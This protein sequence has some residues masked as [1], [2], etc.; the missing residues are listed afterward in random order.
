MKPFPLNLKHFKKI[1]VDQHSSVLKHKDGHEIRIAH[2]SLKPELRKQ[3]DELPHYADGTPKGP[4]GSADDDQVVR[5]DPSNLPGSPGYNLSALAQTPTMNPE[6]ETPVQPAQPSQP[7]SP[8]SAPKSFAQSYSDLAQKQIAALEK[9]KKGEMMQAQALSSGALES[10]NRMASENMAYEQTMEPYNQNR[11]YLLNEHKNLQDAITSGQLDTNR[12]VN[13]MS[14]G[15][16]ILNSLGLIF[17]GFGAGLTHGP[18]LAYNMLEN[19]INND[20]MAQKAELGKKENL[21]SHNAQMLGDNRAAMDMLRM[22][23]NEVISNILKQGAL[24]TQN[25]Q[26]KGLQIALAGKFDADTAARAQQMAIQGMALG[27]GAPSSAKQPA[28]LQPEDPSGYVPLMVPKEHQAQVFKEINAAQDTRR[29]AKSIVDAFDKAAEENTVLRTGAGLLRTPASV[30]AL[31]QAMQPTFK[32]LEGTVRQA[33]MDN[34]FKNITPQPGDKDYTVETKR[35]ALLDYLQSKAS[36]ST[37]KG[38]GID[39]HRFESTAPYTEQKHSLEGQQGFVP[40][41]GRVVMRNGKVVKA[42]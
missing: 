28:Q 13:S 10:K 16:K 21:L 2:A 12:W 22:Q 11:N 36:A 41:I 18:N 25:E 26:S 30:Y 14:G 5:I 17:G 38:Y 19:D 20:I 15:Q 39:L 35:Q 29:M 32:D 24:T 37:A 1:K 27:V 31:H 3:L 7:V 4:V 33:A 6:F 9:Q 34:T 42:Q 8:V 40:G 23:H